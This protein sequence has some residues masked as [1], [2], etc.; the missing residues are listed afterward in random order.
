[1]ADDHVLSDAEIAE[2]IKALPGWEYREG[3]IR[4]S[5]KTGGWPFTLMLVNAIGFAA[6]AAWHHPDLTV[7]WGEVRVRLKTHSAKGITAKDLELARRIEALA[8][9]QPDES[10]PLDG[11]EKGFKKKWVR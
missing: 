6:E 8:T 11:F 1:M 5:Y 3:W 7:T 2:A 10:S 4:R 9:W